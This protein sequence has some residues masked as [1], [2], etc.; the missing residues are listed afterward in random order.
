MGGN[1][2]SSRIEK[3]GLS[4]F[5]LVPDFISLTGSTV[6]GKHEPNDIDITIRLPQGVFDEIYQHNRDL[7]DALLLKLQRD[8]GS[9]RIHLIPSAVGPNWMH[10]PLYDLILRPKRAL[11]K[12]DV[13]EPEFAKKNYSELRAASPEIEK[14]A[15]ETEKE[16]R[17]IPFRFF[18]PA[19]TALSAVMYLKGK[20]NFNSVIEWIEK[21]NLYGKV[22]AQKKYDGVSVILFKYGEKIEFYSEDGKQVDNSKF[23]GIIKQLNCVESIICVGEF[24]LWKDGKHLNR[25]TVAGYLH[26][27]SDEHSPGVYNIHSLLYINGEDIHLEHESTRLSKLYETFS[28]IQSTIGIPLPGINIVPSFV[29]TDR[30]KTVKI[31]KRLV[32]APASEGAMLKKD[33]RYIFGYSN[34]LL[35]F[36]KYETLKAIVWK[37]NQTRVPTVFTYQIAVLPEKYKVKKEDLVLKKYLS[38]GRTYPTNAKCSPGDIISILF[39]SF[40]LYRD[41]EGFYSANAY[42]PK[43]Y[44]RNEVESQPDSLNDIVE[45]AKLSGLLVQKFIED[46]ASYDPSTVNDDILRDDFRL[47]IA[48]IVNGIRKYPRDLVVQKLKEVTKE[49]LKRGCA[50]LHPEKC[51]EEVRRVVK[52]VVKSAVVPVIR[53]SEREVH[54]AK[55]GITK[56]LVCGRKR[57][58]GYYRIN[59]GSLIYLGDEYE[60]G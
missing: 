45:K 16:D 2:K 47:L 8:F 1:T 27:K 32:S 49:I 25:E 54:L 6:Y 33:Q 53:L 44:E 7:F 52:E 48:W 34:G 60:S 51:P 28:K 10:V 42:E 40:N 5:V 43:F 23:G 17:V 30:D 46:L 57:E 19:K 9:E 37:V 56:L 31:L 12:T 3:P 58:K 14:Q 29:L 26:Q 55:S 50:R 15:L 18:Y 11:K 38:I 41:D 22:I 20:P 36:K 59:D 21:E 4:E 24:E 13:G 35:K 39:H